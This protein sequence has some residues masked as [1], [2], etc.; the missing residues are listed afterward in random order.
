[1]L[2]TRKKK[3]ILPF[4]KPRQRRKM[5]FWLVGFAVLALVKVWQT[6]TVDEL[7]RKN[8]QLKAELKQVEDKNAVLKAEIERLKREERIVEI[9]NRELGLVH[10][11]KIGLTIPSDE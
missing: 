3:I 1:M 6:V 4:K 7:F 11:P 5:I 10:A 8:S 2:A 9:A